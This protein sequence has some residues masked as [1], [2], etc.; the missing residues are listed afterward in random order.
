MDQIETKTIYQMNIPEFG[1]GGVPVNEAAKIFGKSA[2]WVRKG[3]EEGWLP[4]GTST[5]S[6]NRV[7]VYISPKLL[8]EYTGYI[9]KG[10]A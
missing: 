3:V 2:L 1:I 8:W 9:W 7:N 10:E 6:E 5:K 4:I